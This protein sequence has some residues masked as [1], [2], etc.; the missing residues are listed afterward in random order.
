MSVK[1][2]RRQLIL[3]PTEKLGSIQEAAEFDTLW[4]EVK[5]FMR[6]ESE[7]LRQEILPTFQQQKEELLALIAAKDQEIDEL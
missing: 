4:H 5:D 1:P 6:K 7:S 2:V 3:Q